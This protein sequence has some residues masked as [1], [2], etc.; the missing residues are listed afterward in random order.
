MSVVAS[1]ERAYDDLAYLAGRIGERLAG[2]S[3]EQEGIGYLADA[4]AA[5]G[6]APRIEAVPV[7]IWEERRTTLVTRE[8]AISALSPCFSGVT[9]D[10]GVTGEIVA[11]G[12]PMTVSD[13]AGRDLAGRLALIDGRDVQVD[14]PDYPQTDLLVAHGVAGAIYAAGAAQ[15]GGLPQAY[16]N[17]KRSLHQPTPPSLV[18]SRADAD[19]LVA[20][21][22]PASLTVAGEVRWSVSANVWAELPGT[23]LGDEIVVVAAH[24]D[25]VR[26]SPGA[27]DNAGGCAV[28]AELARVFAAGPVP[29]RTIRFVH[30]GAHEV[31][32]FGSESWLRAHVDDVSRIAAVINFDGHG[33]VGGDQTAS[34]LGGAEWVS[35]SDAVL[36]ATGVPVAIRYE[37]AGG[38]GV[39]SVNFAALGRNA[40][41][42]G[43]GG[44]PRAHTP[45]DSLAPLGPAGLAGALRMGEALLAATANRDDHDL[46]LP[47]PAAQVRE[48]QSYC[49][50]W[51]WGIAG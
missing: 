42:F 6:L 1:A 36:A 30:F 17:F 26:G 38:V 50:R 2:T 28:V 16:Y 7:P 43:N 11:V 8:R 48:T 34:L 39:D 13:L 14:Y 3:G 9:P 22:G 31:G 19:W 18:I 46:A 21:P 4:F 27:S 35:L 24:H 51:G 47:P 41:N 49:A 29:R 25:A 37:A 15:E 12:D 23:D 33:L 40:I 5:S 10:E 20:N 44:A 32:L 45:A